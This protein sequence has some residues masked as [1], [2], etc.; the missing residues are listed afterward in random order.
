MAQGSPAVSISSMGNGTVPHETVDAA[1]GILKAVGH[2]LRFRIV[3]LLARYPALSRQFA[4]LDLSTTETGP[5]RTAGPLQRR[6]EGAVG[7][8]LVNSGLRGDA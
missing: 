6:L 5:W 8:P 3:D 2:P 7:G 4:G 1:V